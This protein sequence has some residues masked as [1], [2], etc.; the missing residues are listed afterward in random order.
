MDRQYL[1]EKL[2]DIYESVSRVMCIVPTGN[3]QSAFTTEGE[4]IAALA[5][6][7]EVEEKVYNLGRQLAAEIKE[8]F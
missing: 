4:E 8:E 7:T 2:T 3:R 1:Q 5:L 6:L